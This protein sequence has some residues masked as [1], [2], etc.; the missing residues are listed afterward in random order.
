MTKI[1]NPATLSA[2]DASKLHA[3]FQTQNKNNIFYWDKKN[4]YIFDDGTEFKFSHSVVQRKRHKNENEIRYEFISGTMVG[5]G[6]Y[7]KV[8]DI[9]GT[10]TLDSPDKF[11]YKQAGHKKKSRVVKI[12]QHTP[13]YPTSY[14]EKECSY[15]KMARHLAIKTPTLNENTSYLVMRKIKGR[16]LLAIINDDLDERISITL[17]Q[18]ID[19][20]IALSVMLKEQA[21]DLDLIH[22]DVKPENIYVD[23]SEPITANLLDYAFCKKKDVVDN[24]PINPGSAVYAAPE[25]F[26]KNNTTDKC[27]VF[28]LGRVLA[29]IWR[30][31][32]K[33]YNLANSKEY[34][35]NAK[36]IDLSSLFTGLTIKTD[37]KK[38]LIRGTLQL[39][40]DAFPTNRPS[41]DEVIRR[42]RALNA[43]ASKEKG[44]QTTV[45]YDVFP[46]YPNRIN[47]QN[48]TEVIS[49]SS[50]SSHSQNSSKEELPSESE[51]LSLKIS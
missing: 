39:M 16:S 4:A 19:L 2:E 40:M 47:N 31:S 28:S 11:Q 37:T 43:S 29:M 6:S 41:I 8:Y 12:Q 36:N 38:R 30:I 24:N 15:S 33:S 34:F 17:Q 18:R 13:E 49:M 26:T 20:T 7:G 1:I 14:V 25:Q 10:L 21:T 44:K 51:M 22:R 3:W 5:Y 45:I 50:L 42:F 32:S 48:Q 35:E 23:L 46:D 9:A 27:D